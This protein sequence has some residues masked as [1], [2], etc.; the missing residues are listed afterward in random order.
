MPGLSQLKKFSSDVLSMGDEIRLRALR[1]ERPV[2]VPIPKDVQDINDAEDFI[3]GIPEEENEEDVIE[4][5]ANTENDNISDDD[6]SSDGFSDTPDL[7]DILNPIADVSGGGS[8]FPDLSEFG[9]SEAATPDEEKPEEKE[10]IFPELVLNDLLAEAGFDISE[11]TNQ[12]D[13]TADADESTGLLDDIVASN[14]DIAGAPNLDFLS[15]DTAGAPN[16][17]FLNDDF[18]LEPPS[19]AG[20]EG[21]AEEPKEDYKEDTAEITSGADDFDEPAAQEFPASTDDDFHYTGTAID[22]TADLPDEVTERNE[23][24]VAEKETENLDAENF[25][26]D[27][28]VPELDISDLDIGEQT[29]V[30]PA[31]DSESNLDDFTANDDTAGEA[32]DFDL[33]TGDILAE[34][35]SDTASLAE[36]DKLSAGSDSEG[37]FGDMDFNMDSTD[38]LNGSD[39]DINLPSGDIDVDSLLNDMDTGAAAETPDNSFADTSM[40]SLDDTDSGAGVSEDSSF[41][42]GDLNFAVDSDSHDENAPVETFDTSDMEGLDFSIPSTDAQISGE[43]SYSDSDLDEFEIPGF[44]DTDT[45]ETKGGK[46]VA[47]KS[48]AEKDDTAETPNTL[49]DDEYKKFLINLSGYPLN[50][51]IAIEDMLVK[52]EFTDDAEFEVIK[53]VIKK[54]PARQLAGHLEKMLDISLPVPRDFERRTVAEYEAIKSSFR[55]QLKNRII[56]L[57]VVSIIVAGLLYG[58]TLAS[59]RFIVKP[60]RANNYYKQG[61]ALIESNDYPQSEILFEKAAEID[62]QKQWF[63]KYARAYR[64]NKQ[65]DRS[66]KMYRNILNYFAHDKQAGLEYAEME[67][68]DLANYE[69]AENV[70]RRDVLDYHVND[71]DALLMLGDVFLE[72][73]TERDPEKF[74][75]ARIQYA[76]LIEQQNANKGKDT[77]RMNLYLS[78]MMRYFV[79]VDN[80]KEV[81]ALKETFMGQIERNPRKDPLP[82]ED[83][84]EMSGYL[85]DKLFGP[86]T[87]AEEYLRRNIE[88][89]LEMLTR[90][91]LTNRENPVS[92]Y[93]LARYYVQMNN[94]VYARAALKQ[95]LDIFSDT[96]TLKPRDVY[97]YIDAYRLL[98]E[99][100]IESNEM[101]LARETY[102]NGLALYQDAH[103]SSGLAG[104]HQIGLLFADMGDMD[105]FIEGDYNSA[106]RN[107][108]ESVNLGNDTSEVRYKL[109]YIQY[110]RQDYDEALNSFLRSA[111]KN[112]GD[113]NL[114]LALAN[115]L[116]LRGNSYAAEG[117]YSR[118]MG[119]LEIERSQRDV[120]LP[121][122]SEDDADFV[123]LMMRAS[124]NY[125]VTL[126]NMA[127]RTGS[128]AQNAQAMVQLSL[129]MR[130]WD[131]LTRNQLS[132]ERIGGSNLAEQNIAYMSRPI[133]SFEPTIYTDIWNTLSNDEGLGE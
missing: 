87:P 126:Y 67:F 130:A 12:S 35:D 91:V 42:M 62:L 108:L 26:F 40:P 77:A 7:S 5:P 29:D 96:D 30:V 112:P 52:N 14:D 25:D 105:Y 128:S 34:Q 113:D 68:M 58:I 75:D 41:D 110:Y 73:A 11:D 115:T 131:A 127:A 50:V 6:I 49:T 76:S 74:E 33:D 122:V 78:R 48:A 22:L 51:R 114:L 43:S 89:V 125:G 120:L 100:Y 15:D 18:G 116:A 54:V 1:G 129:S 123:E 81:L 66:E 57:A 95:A 117:Y 13:D 132:L 45:A 32:G 19:A 23:V 92:S 88:D 111:D 107:Y 9:E 38:S 17:D 65:Y 27:A 47:P 98:G 2:V 104:T 71:P 37:G 109:G 70:L 21:K 102:T 20:N 36:Y 4:T 101:L 97:K 79:R 83:W 63:F 8:D 94:S 24:G 99:E 59:M 39:L 106:Y 121:Q 118:L 124:N 119:Q 69:K 28:S 85:F 90:A 64:A 93:N 60:L 84:T 10:E 46:F 86:L 31:E 44:S 80:L 133:S 53:K 82:G 72:W 3:L 55:Y 103:E 16:L 56:P 61:Y